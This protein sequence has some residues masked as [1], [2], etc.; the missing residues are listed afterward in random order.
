MAMAPDR[1]C[2]V[3]RCRACV[4]LSVRQQPEARAFTVATSSRSRAKPGM[5]RVWR[6]T[7]MTLVTRLTDS[8]MTLK[9]NR[10]ATQP[11]DE[12]CNRLCM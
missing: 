3:G 1:A 4:G 10:K 5:T 2:L 7:P 11:V 6:P 9:L 12:R 8:A